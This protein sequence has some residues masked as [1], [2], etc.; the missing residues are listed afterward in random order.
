MCVDWCSLKFVHFS[1]LW[2][3]RSAFCSMEYASESIDCKH[4]YQQTCNDDKNGIYWT[5][6]KRNWY[7]KLQFERQRT[8][9]FNFSS[10]F[11]NHTHSRLN[12]ELFG[13]IYS[14]F[15]YLLPLSFVIRT[16]LMNQK[17]NTKQENFEPFEMRWILTLL[18]QAW[19]CHATVRFERSHATDNTHRWI[20]KCKKL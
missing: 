9:R 10:C 13:I 12:P 19:L 11:C 17:H 8:R 6:P 16:K 2:F 4:F 7:L 1:C 20:G 18:W 5:H 15:V 14:L 3:E